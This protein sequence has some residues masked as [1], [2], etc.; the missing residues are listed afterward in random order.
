MVRA[1]GIESSTTDRTSSTPESA[2][3]L[4][5]PAHLRR[6]LQ[7]I[8]WS[9]VV[10][11]HMALLASA[12]AGYLAASRDSHSLAD[13]AILLTLSGIVALVSSGASTWR[14]SWLL[15]LVQSVLA[16]LASVSSRVVVVTQVMLVSAVLLPVVITW[17]GR[18][19]FWIVVVSLLIPS[20]IV[21][22]FG[23]QHSMSIGFTL[24]ATILAAGVAAAVG[25]ADTAVAILS[26]AVEEL[27]GLR[28]AIGRISE[29]NIQYQDYATHIA[30]ESSLEE[31][32]RISRDLH[33]IVGL[34]YTNIIA[35][36]NAVLSRPLAS[37]DEQRE[38]Y[39]WV[40]E[41]AQ[42]GLRNTR[43]ILYELRAAPDQ[44]RPIVEVIA[45]LV[46]AFRTA[47]RMSV[48]VEWGNLPRY[49]PQTIS[50]AVIHLVQEALVNSFRHGRASQVELYFGV[51]GSSLH[52]TA[53][54]NGTGGST[55]EH[56]IGQTGIAERFHKINGTVRFQTSALGYRVDATVPLREAAR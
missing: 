24:A 47:T 23:E 38:L 34:T 21:W 19:R 39:G 17:S 56:G 10:V 14:F 37:A 2:V 54:D 16:G 49:L 5:D 29:A 50:T 27:E 3:T 25:L 1:T 7:R 9:T 44:R 26:R 45:R 15:P 11:V 28:D 42:T 4:A 35:M 12:T 6:L 22:R 52:V 48:T 8:V 13:T 20:L 40:R 55:T 51:D 31:R 36:M 18:K 46:D 41:T 43:A 33:D 32:H 53:I 30:D